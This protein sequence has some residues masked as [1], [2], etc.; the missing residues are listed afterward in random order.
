MNLNVETL[1]KM[2]QSLP[3]TATL[4][5]YFFLHPCQL[6]SGSRF[7]LFPSCTYSVRL[8]HLDGH[9]VD[10]VGSFVDHSEES[11]AAQ[12]LSVDRP[13]QLGRQVS[14]EGSWRDGPTCSWVHL[15]EFFLCDL[16]VF[17]FLISLQSYLT[18]IN[19]F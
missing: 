3:S 6:S 9:L 7:L 15:M 10:S 2:T 16:L 5:K 14:R 12:S 18:S 1:I 8:V 4:T 11:G 13:R 19:C 17:L